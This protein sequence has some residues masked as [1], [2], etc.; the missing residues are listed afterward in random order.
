M[1]SK[2]SRDQLSSCPRRLVTL[3]EGQ[4]YVEPFGM[5]DE[6]KSSS[7]DAWHL[8]GPASRPLYS[9]VSF[10]HLL[11]DR[12]RVFNHTPQAVEQAAPLPGPISC[13]GAFLLPTH[14][15]HMPYGNRRSL[16]GAHPQGGPALL[17]HSDPGSS[18]HFV[19]V[20]CVF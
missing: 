1:L 9:P 13:H 3:S 4:G 14:V 6:E 20:T 12:L 5:D 19:L 16:G 8:L 10:T 18:C 7:G 11:W 17:A 2:Q 15:P